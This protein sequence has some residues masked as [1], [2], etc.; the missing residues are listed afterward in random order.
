MPSVSWAITLNLTGHFTFLK[1]YVAFLKGWLSYDE[2]FV[3]CF[4]RPSC[5]L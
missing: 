2:V 5:N 1:G 4:K 3:T